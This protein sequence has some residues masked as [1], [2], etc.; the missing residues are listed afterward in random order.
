MIDV[1]H[2]N[3]CA[4]GFP[5]IEGGVDAVFLDLPTPWEVV[6][7][8]KRILVP[9]GR[10]C[11]FSPCIE[12]VQ[13][14]CLALRNHGF[15]DIHT[16][17]CLLRT[18]DVTSE[19]SNELPP[20]DA[21]LLRAA[22]LGGSES[23]DAA[24]KSD[25]A[26]SKKRALDLTSTDDAASDEKAQK[27]RKTDSDS[28]SA[29]A[30]ATTPAPAGA[31]GAAVAAVAAPPAVA[32]SKQQRNNKKGGKQQKTRASSI[33]FASAAGTGAAGAG[34]SV[35]VAP[36]ALT[37]KPFPIMRGH[38]GYLTFAVPHHLPDATTAT[39]TAAAATA[40]K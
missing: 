31:A 3:V 10:F 36:P 25:E 8:A 12:Q 9:N 33:S 26:E 27:R 19:E 24:P 28:K 37:I 5:L 34:A 23:A 13:R 39:A 40:K 38:T 14:T 16:I 30:A 15:T 11:S 35:A 2:R 18:F 6:D 21:S 17:E 7:S 29:E 1:Y 4:R 22:G 32:D 20:F